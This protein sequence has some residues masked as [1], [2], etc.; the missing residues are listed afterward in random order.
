MS[1]YKG[2]M[3]VEIYCYGDG[4]SDWEFFHEDEDEGHMAPGM[5]LDQVKDWIDDLIEL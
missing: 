1:E 2:F 4:K 3:I 5:T